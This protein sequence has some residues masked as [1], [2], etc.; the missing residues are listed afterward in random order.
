MLRDTSKHN[1]T[2]PKKT[3]QKVI[4]YLAKVVEDTIANELSN[5]KGAIMYDGCS[6]PGTHYLGIMASYMS[7][8]ALMVKGE[9]HQ[10]AVLALLL[11]LIRPIAAM[12][13]ADKDGQE[14]YE[15][16]SYFAAERHVR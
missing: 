8:I 14:I 12:E 11:L 4:Q 7:N 3:A 1:I 6:R 9:V 10:K 5:T 13:G 16:S 2:F 15:E